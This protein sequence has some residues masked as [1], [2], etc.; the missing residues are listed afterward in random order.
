MCA[1]PAEG[2][3]AQRVPGYEI[4]HDTPV[5]LQNVDVETVRVV[6]VCTRK[7]CGG[8][9][10]RGPVAINNEPF[11]PDGGRLAEY[12]QTPLVG[13]V[14]CGNQ[15]RA[16]FR[17]RDTG[18]GLTGGSRRSKRHGP[19]DDDLMIQ[20]V[21]SGWNLDGCEGRCTIDAGLNRVRG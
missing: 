1:G 20:H 15:H 6:A 16:L 8:A 18:A 19:R 3:P 5:T 10:S 9:G 12:E 4:L 21:I 17:R 2:R 11:E 7:S 14:G 13:E